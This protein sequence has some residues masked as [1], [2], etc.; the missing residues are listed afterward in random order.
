MRYLSSWLSLDPPAP[1]LTPHAVTH[2]HAK[3]PI[4]VIAK[5]RVFPSLD[6]TLAYASHLRTAGA[7]L[8]TIHG[9][10]REAK[11]HQAGLASWEKIA[12]VVAS[13]PG[14]PVLA[15]GGVPSAEELDP[16]LEATGAVGVMSAE[17]N[18]Y[19][20]MIFAP[21][22]VGGGKEYGRCLPVEMQDALR[23]CDGEL[24]GTWAEDAAYGPST[25][26]AAQ[27]L[28]IV[29]TLPST[30]TSSSAIKSHLFKLFRP[31]WATK[32][33]LDL[34]EALGKAGGG[35]M[36][37]ERTEGYSKVVA[38]MLKRLQVRPS[39]SQAEGG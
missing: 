26:L 20:P 29:R 39:V 31:I 13:Q 1:Q 23:A 28:A 10:T 15:N 14:I 33:H 6:R 2:L 25:W 3:L 22:N 5:T 11:G 8:L 37:D 30:R 38:E 16:C 17:G 36:R 4:P 7:Q 19:N 32:R 9:R 27:Y 35:K 18:L 12:A 21:S 24:E 34:R